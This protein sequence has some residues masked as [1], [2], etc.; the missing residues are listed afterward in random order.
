VLN[1]LPER[2]PVLPWVLNV[3]SMLR[4]K[5]TLTHGGYSLDKALFLALDA[6]GAALLLW[7]EAVC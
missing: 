7:R 2:I 3:F 6:L 5:D 4:Q 1:V